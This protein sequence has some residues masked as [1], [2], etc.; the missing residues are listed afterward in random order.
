MAFASYHDQ[1]SNLLPPDER[2][3]ILTTQQIRLAMGVG[4]RLEG[5]LDFWKITTTTFNSGK[6]KYLTLEPLYGS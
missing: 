3:G 2:A 4:N 6:F 1:G 5:P